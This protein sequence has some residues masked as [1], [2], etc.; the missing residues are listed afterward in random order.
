MNIS[1]LLTKAAVSHGR[2]TA[3]ATGTTASCNYSELERRVGTIARILR[4]RYDL[5]TGDRVAVVMANRSGYLEIKYAIWHAGL[6]AV[7]IN[8]GLHAR[9]FQYILSHSGARLCI[10]DSEHSPTVTALVSDTDTLNAVICTETKEYSDL[11]EG[12]YQ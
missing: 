8:A 9:E 5:V 3:L 11:T 10:A 6:V 4:E 7:T 2:L 1:T 12:Q